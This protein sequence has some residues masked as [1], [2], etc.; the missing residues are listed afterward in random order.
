M[1]KV[2]HQVEQ[3]EVFK[4]SKTQKQVTCTERINVQ[5]HIL[6]PKSSCKEPMAAPEEYYYA[7]I[8]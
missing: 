8:W 7:L 5:F 4:G 6:E 3:N 1:A 2:L